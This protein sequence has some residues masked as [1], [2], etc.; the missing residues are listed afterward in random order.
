MS[1]YIYQIKKSE[2][3]EDISKIAKEI[4]KN[5]GNKLHRGTFSTCF[6]YP[7][8]EWSRVYETSAKQ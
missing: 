3:I 4:K 2:S 1:L 7:R 5:I 8:H 6:L